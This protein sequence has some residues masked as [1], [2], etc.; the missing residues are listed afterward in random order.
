MLAKAEVWQL[1]SLEKR[2]KMSCTCAVCS[3]LTKSNHEL[4]TNEVNDHITAIPPA[5]NPQRIFCKSTH[6]YPLLSPEAPIKP[7]HCT[8]PFSG[9]F[10]GPS[11]LQGDISIRRCSETRRGR[12]VYHLRVRHHVVYTRHT[13]SR[14]PRGTQAAMFAVP[15]GELIN[16]YRPAAQGKQTAR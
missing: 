1:F 12:F 15:Q 3:D 16:P 14:R 13:H 4:S 6:R 2:G 9:P 11:P 10:K 5:F 8:P 7:L